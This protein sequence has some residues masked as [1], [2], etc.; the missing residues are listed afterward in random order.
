MP[1][2]CPWCLLL[3]CWDSPVCP[4]TSSAHQLWRDIAPSVRSHAGMPCTLQQMSPGS[5]A[6]QGFDSCLRHRQQHTHQ[7]DLP[8]A[9]L[10][11]GF[12]CF[13]EAGRIM[14]A[15]AGR[16]HAC[17]RPLAACAAPECKATR[18]KIQIESDAD[19][20]LCCCAGSVKFLQSQTQV[21]VSTAAHPW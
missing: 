12:S 16:L 17:S 18:H 20:L 5:A 14:C 2:E 8:A 21:S 19:C 10:S 9:L 11:S 15:A 13:C 3:G 7:Q 6:W 1:G 4:R